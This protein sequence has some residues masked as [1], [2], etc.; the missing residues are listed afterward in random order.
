MNTYIGIGCVFVVCTLVL[1]PNISTIENNQVK[2]INERYL[3][4]ASLSVSS[5]NQF[6]E[7]V[8]I[9]KQTDDDVNRTCFILEKIWDFLFLCAI[10][11]LG[12]LLFILLPLYSFVW[13]KADDLGCEFTDPSC[14]LD[15]LLVK[16]IENQ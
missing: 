12:L 6:K 4:G 16:F 1:I 11:S 2:Q 8:N 10:F 9:M 5:L 13:K 7:I 14:F 3:N 15:Y